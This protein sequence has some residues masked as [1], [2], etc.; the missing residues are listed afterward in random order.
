MKK[1]L[2]ALGCVMLSISMTGCGS[3]DAAPAEKEVKKEPTDLTGTW[4]SEESE[5]TYQEAV[6]NDG[7]I[8]INWINDAEQTKALYWIGSYEAPTEAVDTYSWTSAGDIETMASALL[9]SQDETKDFK[10][11][12]GKI[13][14]EVSAMGV[15]KTVELSKE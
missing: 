1:I 15:T 13:T 8:E 6:I 5:G 12:N 7:T 2:I 11:E 9:A 4:K 10:Y 3:N 14:Y